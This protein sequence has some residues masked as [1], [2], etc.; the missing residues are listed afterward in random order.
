M[1]VNRCH[2]I[3]PTFS[4]LT[5]PS[6]L[7]CFLPQEPWRHLKTPTIN[8][9]SPAGRVFLFISQTFPNF[10]SMVSFDLLVCSYF[11]IKWQIVFLCN[12]ANV[13]DDHMQML[14]NVIINVTISTSP[15]LTNSD[16]HGRD[17]GQH[18]NTIGVSPSIRSKNT[19]V[20]M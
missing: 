4:Y 17:E 16:S 5:I 3:I 7:T 9:P 1:C 19:S 11:R 2:S 13:S 20:H 8:Y 6:L 10:S 14:G 15:I 18:Y 12:G